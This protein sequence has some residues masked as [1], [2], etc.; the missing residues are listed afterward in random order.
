MPRDGRG[1]RIYWL[2]WVVGMV[3]TF[4]GIAQRQKPIEVAECLGIV[5][6]QDVQSL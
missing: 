6:I 2:G 1:V 3:T 4:G 5:N